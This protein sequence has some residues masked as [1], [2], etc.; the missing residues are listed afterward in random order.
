MP[1][2]E[3]DLHEAIEL[4]RAQASTITGRKYRYGAVLL[5]D[6][7]VLRVSSNKTPFQRNA[8]HAEMAALKGC[9]RPAGKDVCLVRLAPVRPGAP[10]DEDEDSD[11]DKEQW[12][13]AEC[14]K[15]TGSAAGKILNAKPCSACELKMTQR[16]ICR[17]Y[18]TINRGEMGVMQLNP[19]T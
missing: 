13:A 1:S 7:V 15:A 6:D 19:S 2:A 4:A 3:S 9:P 17:V 14:P 10:K 18:Y 8:I 16:G 12:A 5:A 11:E